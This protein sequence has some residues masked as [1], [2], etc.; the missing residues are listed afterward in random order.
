MLS[1]ALKFYLLTLFLLVAFLFIYYPGLQGDFEFDDSVNILNNPHITISSISFDNLKQAALSGHAGPTKRPI[2]IISFA[3]NYYFTGPDP[4]YFKATNLVVHLLSG[5]ALYLFCYLLLESSSL[6]NQRLKPSKN[7]NRY[8]SLLITFIWLIHPINLTSVLYIVQRMTSLSGLFVLFA[9]T[10][11][12]LGR[13]KDIIDQESSSTYLYA[14]I[15]SSFFGLLGVFSK[16]NATLLPLYLLLIESFIFKFKSCNPIAKKLLILYFIISIS[17]L[18]YLI[19]PSYPFDEW[20]KNV[21]ELRPFNLTERLL[22][23]L[24]VVTSYIYMIFVPNNTTLGIYHDDLIL[25]TSL[26]TPISTLLSLFFLLSL[27]SIAVYYTKKTPYISFAILWFFISHLLESTFIPLE[28]MHEHRNYLASFG[29][30]FILIISTFTLAENKFSRKFFISIIA[31]YT[32]YLSL[33]T[34]NRV[35]EWSNLELHAHMES[36][37]HHNS[38]RAQYQLGRIYFMHYAK[39]KN[40][41]YFKKSKKQFD[42]V[43]QINPGALSAHISKLILFS[44]AKDIEVYQEE[45]K[46]ISEIQKLA[47]RII[48]APKTIPTINN[49]SECILAQQC[50]IPPPEYIKFM[51]NLINNPKINNNSKAFIYIFL[52]DY[53]RE[54]LKNDIKALESYFLAKKEAP[55]NL[56]F[57]IRYIIGLANTSQYNSALKHIAK[58]RQQDQFQTYSATL[59]D[60]EDKLLNTLKVHHEHTI[61]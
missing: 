8:L 56:S 57:Q 23:E 43:I 27:L 46:T 54:I 49:L 55:Q 47:M 59:N 7:T 51:N 11:Y 38:E 44:V 24:R 6:I 41:K 5:L 30:I 9:C 34:Y 58:T 14:F 53:F 48:I 45:K 33:T 19:F 39:S 21:Y 13:K 28:L 17:L 52:G 25:S 26:F 20:S 1:S 22:T 18:F 40:I 31:L 29:L 50:K 10:L 3:T 60:I 35:I 15:G 4:F 61:Q 32:S 2:S 36:V 42:K 16:E 37:H 12:I